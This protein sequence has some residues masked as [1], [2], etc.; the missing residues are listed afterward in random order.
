MFHLITFQNYMRMI[1]VEPYFLVKHPIQGTVRFAVQGDAE[2]FAEDLVQVIPMAGY[3]ILENIG[4][5]KPFTNEHLLSYLCVPA[6]KLPLP[7]KK[8]FAAYAKRRARNM[9]RRR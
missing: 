5:H 1:I 3:T 6:E 8:F 2:E 7:E 9:L 4:E